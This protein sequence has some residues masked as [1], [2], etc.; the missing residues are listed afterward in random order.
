MTKG[1]GAGR[2]VCSHRVKRKNDLAATLGPPAMFGCLLL[3]QE[4]GGKNRT[5]IRI[6]VESEYPTGGICGRRITLVDSWEAGRPVRGED[7]TAADR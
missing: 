4:L 5:A 2:P 3:A 6:Q 7:S 1:N